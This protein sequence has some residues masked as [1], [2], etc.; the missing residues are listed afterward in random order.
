MNPSAVTV[1]R[2]SGLNPIHERWSVTL[3]NSGLMVLAGVELAEEV[4][5]EDDADVEAERAAVV[6]MRRSN[7][8]AA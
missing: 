5:A 8:V 3:K 4:E 6:S 2:T 1:L 7:I